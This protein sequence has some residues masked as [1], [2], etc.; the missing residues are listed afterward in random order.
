MPTVYFITHADVQ[1][2][3]AVAVPEWPLSSRGRERVTRLVGKPWV[4]GIRAIFSS[5]ERK[6]CD[7]ARILA[8]G[9]GIGLET[10]AALGENDRS[11]T[12]FLPK[13]E[14]EAVADQFFAKPDE[15]VRGWERAIDDAYWRTFAAAVAITADDYDVV[16]FG[17]GPALADE[18][19]ALVLAGTKRA[20]ACLLRDVTGAGEPMPRVGGHVVVLDGARVPRCIWRTTEVTVKPLIQV[21]DAFAWDEGEGDRSRTDWLD[22]HRRYFARQAVR[23]GFAFHDDI[24]TVF[25]RFTIV[26]PPEVADAAPA[27]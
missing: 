24:A 26:W 4:R 13:V 11:A 5:T 10:V 9:L 17:D 6:A 20:T 23:E 25:E 14:F 19:L 1:I 16:A 7:G 2:D 8:E 21:D 12:G 3:P 22:G 15:S 27:R 18:L